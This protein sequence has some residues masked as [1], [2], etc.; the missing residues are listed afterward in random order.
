MLSLKDGD[1]EKK[2]KKPQGEKWG[3]GGGRVYSKVSS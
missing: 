3:R 2:L 1:L